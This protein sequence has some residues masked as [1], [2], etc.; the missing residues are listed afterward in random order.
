[1]KSTISTLNL[2]LRT[3]K[4]ERCTSSQVCGIATIN[5]TFYGEAGQGKIGA[6]V[7]NNSCSDAVGCQLAI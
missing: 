3:V 4:N 2:L 7:T 5:I 6:C 1:M